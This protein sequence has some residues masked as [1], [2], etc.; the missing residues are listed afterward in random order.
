MCDTASVLALGWNDW[1]DVF[2]I[3]YLCSF[4]K[5]AV[6]SESFDN[7]GS[8][9]IGKNK[10]NLFTLKINANEFDYNNLQKKLLE[11][12]ADFSLSNLSLFFL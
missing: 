11:P 1:L 5:K 10:L 4:C 2:I 6:F 8:F 9:D 3:I 12:M 7:I